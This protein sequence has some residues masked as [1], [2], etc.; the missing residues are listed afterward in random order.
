MTV[1]RM[2]VTDHAFGGVAHERAIAE[3]RGVELEVFQCT[4]PEET[5]EAVRGA[6]VVLV[7]FAPISREVLDALEPGATVIRYG[8][9]YDNVDVDAARARGI[10]VCNVPDYGADTVADHTL[11]CLLGLARR[12]GEYTTGIRAR[13][14]VATGEFGRVRGFAETTVGLIGTGRIGQAVIARLRPFGFHVVAYDPFVSSEALEELGV[15]KVSFDD[16]LARA[17]IVSLHTPLTPEN[18]HLMN[19][20]AFAHMQEGAMLVNTSRGGL[21]D[22]SAL[23]SALA[24][25]HLAGAALD[26]FEPEPLAPN[27]ALRGFDNVILTPHA[28]FY[29]ESS[30]D[31]LQRLAAEEAGRAFDGLELRCRVT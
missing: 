10:R 16:L 26:V 13:G 23:A 22:E 1:R 3:S 19:E 9:G 5:R 8:I 18:R 7:N 15:E 31:A 12:T 2:V 24:A 11:A 17:H 6:E 14:W 21:V 29:S 25:G 4:Q 20:E 28:A 30:L 27:S